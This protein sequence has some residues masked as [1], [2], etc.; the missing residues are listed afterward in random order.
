MRVNEEHICRIR[1]RI[2]RQVAL[3]QFASA[4]EVHIH[5]GSSA[6]SETAAGPPATQ[7]KPC[8][9]RAC[10]ATEV[11]T[12]EITTLEVCGKQGRGGL[13]AIFKPKPQPAAH[14]ILTRWW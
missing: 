2:V 8:R 3:S 14:S 1:L 12:A 6:P 7:S 13:K 10:D 5:F 11:R 4:I 9:T